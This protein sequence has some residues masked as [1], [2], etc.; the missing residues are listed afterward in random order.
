MQ[1]IATTIRTFV[2]FS[3]VDAL[4]MVWH[5][6]YVRYMEDARE[7]FGIEHGL[8]YVDMFQNGY[9]APVVDIHL[10][11]KHSATINDVLRTTIKYH[12]CRGGKLMFDY[13]MLRETDN[14]EIL[15]ATSI[16]LFTTIDGV[17]E[18]SCP[19]FL[20]QWRLKHNLL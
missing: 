20:Q 15:T 10:Q 17:L 4:K 18:V 12:H 3:E 11:Y 14:V 5:G 16:Q 7:A 19:E 9:L 1:E 13:R 6:N 8:A 2:R